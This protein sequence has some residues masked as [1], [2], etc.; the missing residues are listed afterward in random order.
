MLR[1]YITCREVNDNGSA[2]TLF[3]DYQLNYADKYEIYGHPEKDIS[4]MIYEKVEQVEEDN[5]EF[6]NPL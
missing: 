4:K 5:L 1:F 2:V 3:E 6:A